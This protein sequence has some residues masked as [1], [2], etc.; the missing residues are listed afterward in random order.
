[1]QK[2]QDEKLNARICIRRADNK[3]VAK[4]IERK[5]FKERKKARYKEKFKN[6]EKRNIF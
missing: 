6:Y 3:F 4:N 1:M 5:A 2:Y